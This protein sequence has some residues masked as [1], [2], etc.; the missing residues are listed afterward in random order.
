VLVDNAY[1]H[2]QGLVTLRARGSAGA[3]AIDVLDE[4]H[5]AS[6][7]PPPEEGLGLS[8]ATSIATGQGGRLMQ[9]PVDQQTRL[10]LLLPSDED[11]DQGSGVGTGDGRGR[12]SE[13]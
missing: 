6:L 7:L 8:L 12:S 4:G 9:G 13:A 1:R 11:G 10:T 3:L 5:A 2:G